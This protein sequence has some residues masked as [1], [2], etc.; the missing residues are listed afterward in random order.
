MAIKK[1]G[2]FAK[3]L[4]AAAAARRALP[5]LDEIYLVDG[6]GKLQTLQEGKLIDGRFQQNIRIDL[7]TH[8]QGAGQSH[9]HVRGRKGNELVVVNFD[10]TASH[11]TSGRLHDRDADALRKRGFT[12]PD[13][14]IVEWV[15]DENFP[16]LLT[17]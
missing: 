14:N 11:G 16:H 4:D 17:G 9:A 10:G 8:L 2:A 13:D 12:I 15:V 1:F 5:V 6:S 7:A 3:E